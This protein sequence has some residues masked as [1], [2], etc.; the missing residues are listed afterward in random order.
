MQKGQEIQNCYRTLLRKSHGKSRFARPRR[1]REDNIK[2]DLRVI[3]CEDGRWTQLAQEYV[4]W[5]DLVL[6]VL[7]LRFLLPENFVF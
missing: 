5:L 2:M 4:H 7:N 1:R 3:S 6:A